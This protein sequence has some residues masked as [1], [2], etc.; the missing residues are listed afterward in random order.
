VSGTGN[1]VTLVGTA[2]DL[3]LVAGAATLVVR[4]RNNG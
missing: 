3:A 1:A 4:R 2:A